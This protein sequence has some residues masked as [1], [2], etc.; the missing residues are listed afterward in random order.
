MDEYS[1]TA[2]GFETDQLI[3]LNFDSHGFEKNVL[4]VI[5]VYTIYTRVCNN[6][7]KKSLHSYNLV[8]EFMRKLLSRMAS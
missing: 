2:T 3:K 4:R 7:E 8:N 6:N 5:T 1:K